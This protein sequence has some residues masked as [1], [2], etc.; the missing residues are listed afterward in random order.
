MALAAMV[1]LGLAAD[2]PA[3]GKTYPLKTCLVS[4]QGLGGMGDPYVFTYQGRE[5][6]LCCKG[7]LKQFNKE[8]ASYL[9]KLDEAEK[10]APGKQA[11][12]H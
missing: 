6:K 5:I 10:A 2:Q 7:C 3:K 8:P 9:K 1:P 12:Q 4:G 11:P